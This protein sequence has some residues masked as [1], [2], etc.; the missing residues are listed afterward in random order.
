MV[1]DLNDIGALDEFLH[2]SGIL[3][4]RA[5]FLEVLV[6]LPLIATQDERTSS[7]LGAF[8]LVLAWTLSVGEY[9]QA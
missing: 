2:S 9:S 4:K 8:L 7:F 3:R 1:M 5:V 6:P